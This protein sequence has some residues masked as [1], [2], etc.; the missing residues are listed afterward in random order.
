MSLR[1]VTWC[2]L[3]A[4]TG[5]TACDDRDGSCEPG[6]LRATGTTLGELGGA[7][8]L[9]VGMF[10]FDGPGPA[11]VCDAYQAAV[12]EF[13]MATLPVFFRQ[14]QEVRGQFDFT[15]ADA[16][17]DA[18]PPDMTFFVP[19]LIWNDLL[20]TWLTDGNF[21]GAERRAFLVEY[22]TEVITHFEAK[23][24]GRVIGYELVLEPLSWPA[25]TGFWHR[26]G[27][28]A[29]ED[30]YAYIRLALHTANA[31]VPDTK[32]Y[33]DDFAVEIAGDRL[34][35]Y[36]ALATDLVAAGA[37]LDGIGFEC[38]FSI[39]QGGPFPHAPSAEELA[40]NLDRFAALG[41]E[42]MVTSLD[43]A[44]HDADRSEAAFADQAEAYRRVLRGC[45][46]ARTCRGF[47][48][49]GIGDPDTWLLGTDQPEW[50]SPLMFDH[51]YAPK[52]AFHA[53]QL[54]LATGN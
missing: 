20:P 38:H 40:T 19:G 45:L 17:A 48:T 51:A 41:L 22:V 7:R 26:V 13:G 12:R 46:G 16:V 11:S 54:E 50:A 1:Y 32:L 49:W 37:P 27:L 39:G 29:G 34:E 8:G 18:M 52:P 15:I 42:T 25:A 53:V 14:I 3:A 28:D 2:A 36:V 9:E 47:S 5:A 33:I 31:L 35:R 30:P 43:V 10:T 21:T 24:P 23:Y 4:A 6:G 44:V